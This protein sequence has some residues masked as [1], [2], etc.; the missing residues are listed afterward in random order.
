MSNRNAHGAKPST[1][2]YIWQR[3][4]MVVAL[5]NVL[6]LNVERLALMTL[7][8]CA[9]IARK[10]LGLISSANLERVVL[11]VHNTGDIQ[12]V[13][14]LTIS[15]QH[16]YFANNFL[17]SNCD[18]ALY[19]WRYTYNHFSKPLKPKPKPEDKIDEFW[20]R[21]ALQIEQTKHRQEADDGWIT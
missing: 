6:Q 11:H 12:K 3:T 4:K 10:I 18:A 16:E 13:Y 9:H 15:P 5:Q 19:A 17:V 1:Q 14:N 20:E 7:I 2:K 21:E 8:G